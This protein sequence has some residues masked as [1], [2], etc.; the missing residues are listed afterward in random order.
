[1]KKI[2][3]K[4]LNLFGDFQ[5]NL[6]VHDEWTWKTDATWGLAMKFAFLKFST[7]GYR[8]NEASSVIRLFTWRSSCHHGCKSLA[9][10]NFSLKSLFYFGWWSTNPNIDRVLYS[11]KCLPSNKRFFGLWSLIEKGIWWKGMSFS[12][13][14]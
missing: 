8:K 3:N 2:F 4:I 5:L 1:M 9:L 13:S 11:Q 7:C 6:V 14:K 10:L 12:R